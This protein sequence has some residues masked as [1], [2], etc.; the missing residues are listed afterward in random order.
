MNR[1]ITK[2]SDSDR[3]ITWYRS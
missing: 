2:S 1:M 3:Y